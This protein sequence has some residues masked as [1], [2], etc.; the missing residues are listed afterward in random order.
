MTKSTKSAEDGRNCKEFEACFRYYITLIY[1]KHYWSLRCLIYLNTRLLESAASGSVGRMDK[2][3]PGMAATRASI[4][5]INAQDTYAQST[6]KR[7]TLAQMFWPL[8]RPSVR[9]QIYIRTCSHVHTYFQEETRTLPAR[10]DGRWRLTDC[11]SET[12][13]TG[14][15]CNFNATNGW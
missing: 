3:M 9:L 15:H 1:C 10:L 7:R 6:H 11:A 4:R 8:V 13:N 14:C 2:E 5:L 12:D